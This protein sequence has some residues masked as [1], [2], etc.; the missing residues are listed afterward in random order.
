MYQ[1]IITQGPLSGSY[2]LLDVWV[3]ER[4]YPRRMRCSHD[5]NNEAV[6]R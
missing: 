4:K 1:M 2:V 5:A 6:S 3:S